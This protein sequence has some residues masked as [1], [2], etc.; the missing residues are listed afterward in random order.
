MT[1]RVI[2]H[3]SDQSLPYDGHINLVDER[4]LR[5]QLEIDA[6]NLKDLLETD[7]APA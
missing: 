6:A 7:P 5:R 1:I 2:T 4:M 3:D